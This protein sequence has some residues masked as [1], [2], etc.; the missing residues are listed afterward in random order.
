MRGFEAAVNPGQI[1]ETVRFLEVFC[2]GCPCQPELP[3][4]ACPVGNNP[5]DEECK[6]HRH[7]LEIEGTLEGAH[8]DIILTLRHMGVAV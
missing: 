7:F 5:R 8:M 1:L 6:R 4:E 2:S 3:I